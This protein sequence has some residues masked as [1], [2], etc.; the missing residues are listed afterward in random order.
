MVKLSAEQKDMFAGEIE[1]FLDAIRTGAPAPVTPDES[2][3]VLKIVLA[4]R[5]SLE[6][7]AVQKL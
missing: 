4:T 3:D 5:K 6:E 2:R 7:G 1:G